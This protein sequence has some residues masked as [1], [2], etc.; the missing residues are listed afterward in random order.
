MHHIIYLSSATQPMSDD[1]LTL[2][3][4]QCRRNN[5]R[6]GVTGAL[7]YGGGQFM[8]IMEGESAVVQALYDKVETD[9]R[10]TG[11][12][13]L[14]DKDIP[15]R[16]FGNWSMAFDTVAAEMLL[17]AAGYATPAEMMHNLPTGLSAADNLL[18]AMLRATVG[19]AAH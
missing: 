15:H 4:E 19:E 7:V 18:Y 2:L 8:Q 6:L 17:S 11:V 3:L 16:S 10:H 13:K 1:D 5:E 12:M 9:A 14:A